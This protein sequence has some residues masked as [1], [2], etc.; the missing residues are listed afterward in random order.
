MTNREYV[1]AQIDSLPENIIEKIVEFIS[2]QKYSNGLFK[3]DTEYL[4][5]I[6]GMVDKMKE[7]IN[8]PMSDC[9]PLSEVW[10]D[11][12]HLSDK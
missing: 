10:P 3:D 4:S 5:S 2:F 1:K 7:G 11:Y 9:V 6:P 12:S 8:T